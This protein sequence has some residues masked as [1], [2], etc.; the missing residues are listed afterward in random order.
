MKNYTSEGDQRVDYVQFVWRKTHSCK[1]LQHLISEI[2]SST[3]V[4]GV[5]ISEMHTVVIDMKCAF[6]WAYHGTR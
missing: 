5:L 4:G 1:I 3:E 2:G 6:Y